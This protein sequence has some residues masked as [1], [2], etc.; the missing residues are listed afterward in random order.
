MPTVRGF[1]SVKAQSYLLRLPLFTR[2]IV[3]I[4]LL[5]SLL[6]LPGFWDVQAWGSLVPSK[7]SLF[8]GMYYR[9]EKVSGPLADRL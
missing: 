4:I 5:L 6:S 9:L 8:A 2:A 1:S 7:V 3:L